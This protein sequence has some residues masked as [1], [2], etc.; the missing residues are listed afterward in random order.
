[1]VS[2]HSPNFSMRFSIYICK[3]IVNSECA[4]LFFDNSH[5]YI[6]LGILSRRCYILT[7]NFFSFIGLTLVSSQYG[8]SSKRKQSKRFISKMTNVT[9]ILNI[10]YWE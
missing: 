6:S 1:M 5:S 9:D 8:F 7:I 3:N 2:T 4:K 10:L